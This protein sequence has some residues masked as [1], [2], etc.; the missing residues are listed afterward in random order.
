MRLFTKIFLCTIVVVTAALSIFG[1]LLISTSFA[2]TIER[3]T[4]RGLEEYQILKFTLQA[5]ILSAS[6]NGVISDEQLSNLA[7]QTATITSTGNMTA[8]FDQEKKILFSSFV[9]DY[10]P[11]LTEIKPEELSYVI[12]N[13]ESK[14]LLFI[15][16]YFEQSGR[17]VYLS[18]AMD[19]SSIIFEKR[20]FHRHYIIIFVVVLCVSALIMLLLSLFLTNPIKRLKHVTAR[21]ASGQYNERV[22][23]KTMDEI[24]ELGES[25]NFMA[26]TIE[27]KINEL[28]LNAR[29]KEDFVANF[30]HELK[31]PLTSVIGYAD[32]LYQKDL[33]KSE[34]REAAAFIMNEGMHLETLSFK[35]MELIVLG[36]Q[37]FILE[38]FKADELIKEMVGS[39]LPIMDKNSVKMV[40]DVQSAYIK[41]EYDLMKTLLLNL[42]DNS[43]KAES[44][45]IRIVGI[46]QKGKYVISVV[47]DGRGIPEN[48]LTRITEA[49]YM[50]DKAR[51][52]KQHGAGLGVSIAMRIAEIHGTTL[53]YESKVGVG[54]KVSFELDV[55]ET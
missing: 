17:E 54:T 48:E 29:Q 4:Q 39:L 42:I 50:V 24:G 43:S 1:Y 8:I 47:D 38:E 30:A 44:M 41:V 20:E 7:K 55:E 21:L 36:K 28:K 33:T 9:G 51:S 27:N 10:L 14:Y 52:R 6:E 46:T 16:G 53:H 37:K 40:I 13:T 15:T 49:F 45:N 26:Q 35:L 12:Q 18:T 23:V 25:F 34:V 11:D 19:V 3:E 2:N 31:T 5:R 32:M 22:H